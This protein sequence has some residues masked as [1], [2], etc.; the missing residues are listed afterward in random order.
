MKEKKRNGREVI[1]DVLLVAGG[2]AVSIGAGVLHI[3]AGLIV[4]GLLAM[5]FGWLIALGGDP[6]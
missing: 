6:K 5:A 1:S 3:A 2:T 4:G